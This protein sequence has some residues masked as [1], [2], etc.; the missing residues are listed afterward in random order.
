VYNSRRGSGPGTLSRESAIEELWRSN[1]QAAN[2]SVLRDVV[3][4]EVVH[5]CWRHPLH[6]HRIAR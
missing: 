6:T 1:T 2:M 4:R 3:S 5:P